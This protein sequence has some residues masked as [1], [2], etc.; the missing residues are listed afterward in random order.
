MRIQGV[1][2]KM[3]ENAS[4]GHLRSQAEAFFGLATDPKFFGRVKLTLNFDSSLV[5]GAF[6]ILKSVPLNPA[7]KGNLESSPSM[8]SR[9]R[10]R[11]CKKNKK[12]NE[13]KAADSESQSAAAAPPQLPVP[14]QAPQQ[15]PHMTLPQ[16]QG[17]HTEAGV[18]EPLALTCAAAVDRPSSSSAAGQHEVSEPPGP[19]LQL[20]SPIIR[21][22]QAN[23][24]KNPVIALTPGSNQV[25]SGAKTPPQKAVPAAAEFS[26]DVPV[27]PDA[28]DVC[29][30]LSDKQIPNKHFV[31]DSDNEFT[32]VTKKRKKRSNWSSEEKVSPQDKECRLDLLEEERRRDES[33]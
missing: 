5:Q 19:I 18:S 33:I 27:Q 3:S 13:D 17:P 30:E 15:P 1:S 10:R 6:A 28:D 25:S 22:A 8:R 14:Q 21:A 4:L 12:K 20:N 7:S 24:A 32:T 11:R 2:R 23:S 26:N 29:S 9:K 31:H 16:C